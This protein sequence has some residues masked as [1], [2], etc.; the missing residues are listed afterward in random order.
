MTRWR[1]RLRNT[2]TGAFAAIGL[3]AVCAFCVWNVVFDRVL[4]L[5]GRRY[6]LA[7]HDAARVNTFLRIDDWM[8]PAA[9]RGFWDASVAG[10]LVLAIGVAG[11]VIAVR[12]P[13]ISEESPR[14]S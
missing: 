4:V 7:A 10:A 5:A 12:R 9:S 11:V 14:K 6:S 8:R 13:T 2:R 3:W 1:G